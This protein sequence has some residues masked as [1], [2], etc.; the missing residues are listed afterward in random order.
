MHLLDMNCKPCAVVAWL[1]R[2]GTLNSRYNAYLIR[3][4][5]LWNLL[6]SEQDRRIESKRHVGLRAI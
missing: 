6:T 5:R 4:N 1:L 3:A 2:A